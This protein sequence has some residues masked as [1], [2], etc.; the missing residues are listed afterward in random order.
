MP[1]S[2]FRALEIFLVLDEGEPHWKDY[3]MILST[4]ART[5]SISG[6]ITLHMI[7][8]I[9]VM[10]SR[11]RL[12]HVSISDEVLIERVSRQGMGPEICNVFRSEIAYSTLHQPPIQR[13]L[14]VAFADL[15]EYIGKNH[16]VN[17]QSV[18]NNTECCTEF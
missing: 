18:V 2:I 9:R 11:L 8:D 13:P 14:S 12:C 10:I 15:L 1:F 3:R 4:M 7:S 6:I 16:F 5:E 17:I